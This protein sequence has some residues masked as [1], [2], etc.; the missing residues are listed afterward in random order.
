M[1]IAAETIEA[2]LEQYGTSHNRNSE[3]I[4]IAGVRTSV[5][6]FQ[7]FIRL[8]DDWVFF[9]IN[10]FVV[11][12]K[13]EEDRARFYYHALRFNHDMNLAKLGVDR[14]GDLFLI[15]E[16]PAIDF[17]YSHFEEAMDALAYH[18]S[19]IYV[20]LLSLA[21]NAPHA[22]GRYDSEFDRE[23]IIIAGKRLRIVNDEL[24]E[25]RIELDTL[26]DDDENENSF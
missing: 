1:S 13:N 8:T 11:A 5:A 9:F 15:V 18:A 23:E 24:G 12:P 2:Y 26:P 4:W 14:D 20:E 3:F 6:P 25:P 7:I 19:T 22:I 10:P 17:A 16:F 21:H